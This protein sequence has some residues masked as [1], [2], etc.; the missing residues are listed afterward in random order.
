MHY[1]TKVHTVSTNRD[2][3]HSANCP[4]LTQTSATHPFMW[5]VDLVQLIFG[6]GVTLYWTRWHFTPWTWSKYYGLQVS[7]GHTLWTRSTAYN[8][9]SATFT[10]HLGQKP[11]GPGPWH[12]NTKHPLDQVQGMLPLH[13]GKCLRN[14]SDTMRPQNGL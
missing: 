14:L 10:L 8:Y 7:Q 4:F 12:K 1:T 11:I 9:T 2:T 13:I 6:R 5:P 3:G